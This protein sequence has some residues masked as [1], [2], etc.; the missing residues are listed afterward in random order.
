MQDGWVAGTW[1][2]K[3]EGCGVRAGLGTH[4]DSCGREAWVVLAVSVKE[5]P[6]GMATQRSAFPPACACL[7]QRHGTWGWMQLYPLSAKGT[8]RSQ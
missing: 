8:A 2:A 4:G 5:L 7:Q 1:L 3:S 6:W